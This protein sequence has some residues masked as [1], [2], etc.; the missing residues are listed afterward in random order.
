MLRRLGF[1]AV[2]RRSFLRLV[3][4]S[5]FVAGSFAVGAVPACSQA[6]LSPSPSPTPSGST[7]PPD[8]E[9]EDGGGAPDGGSPDGTTPGA[10]NLRVMAANISSGASSTYDPGEG[11]RM[12]QGLKPDLALVQEFLVGDGSEDALR[13]FVT[14]T[15]GASFSVFRE[16][17]VQIPNGIVSRYPITES[18]TWTDPQVSN[19]SFAYARIAVPGSHPVVAVSVH[20][21]TTGGGDRN[22]EATALVG[23]IKSFVAPGEYVVIGGDL[24]TESRTESCLSTFSEIVETKGAYP[25]DQAGNDNTNAPRNKPYDWVLVDAALGAHQVPTTIGSKSHPNGL[26]FDS[27]VFTPLDDVA[28]V[29]ADDSA[30]LNMQHM[31]VV[32]DF[33]LSN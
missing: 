10:S 25:A 33:S 15:F 13:A 23:R 17:G 31:P 12:F 9:D 28:P 16:T 27:R 18:G 2:A 29:L 5:S 22:A 3:L 26:V 8:G 14:S 4:A 30:A 21:L 24:N 20:L 32:R 7:T 1:S 6:S 19:R 11:K